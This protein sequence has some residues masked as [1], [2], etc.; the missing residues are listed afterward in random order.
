M[1][2]AKI[3]TPAETDG[4]AFWGR[5]F[6]WGMLAVLVVFFIN[7]YLSNALGWP[8]PAGILK[9]AGVDAW[10]QAALYVAGVAVGFFYVRNNRDVSLVDDSAKIT[11]FNTWLIR[12]AFWAVLG[13]GIADAA[14]SFL[15]VEGLLEA[16]VG[17]NLTIQLGRPIFRG[18]YVHVPLTVLGF[19]VAGFTRT[20]GFQ[21]LALLIVV[22]ELSIVFTRFIFS[23][24]QAFM[25]DLV[26][27]WYGGLFLFASAYTLLSD[28]HVRVDVLY[29]SFRRRTRGIVNSVGSVLLGIS[30]TWT[31]LIIG[32]GSKTGIIYSPVTSFEMSQ[33]GYG[34][35]IK[36]QLAGFLGIFAITMLIQF[37]AFFLNAVSDYI[38]GSDDEVPDASP[39]QG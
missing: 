6:G 19:V 38:H 12:G 10:F 22:A 15:R 5:V 3:E 28:E 34:M 1:T 24:E 18:M 8:G 20:L 39:S 30:L 14:I 25:G 2:T 26:R 13:V 17:E 27:Y 37:V 21:W 29:A 31:I 11:R 32:F 16:V 35:Y 33:S 9:N 7:V 4:L 23:Y 36:Y